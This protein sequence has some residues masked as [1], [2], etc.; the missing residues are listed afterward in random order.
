ML[1]SELE[2]FQDLFS[3]YPELLAFLHKDV[4]A[5]QDYHIDQMAPWMEALYQ[6]AEDAL[7]LALA[8]L[9]RNSLLLPLLENAVTDK[10]SIELER[11]CLCLL[12]LQAVEQK[13]YSFFSATPVLSGNPITQEQFEKLSQLLQSYF[14]GQTKKLL[15]L[16]L[17]LGD[18][19]KIRPLRTSLCKL[20]SIEEQ[21][22][23]QFI[24]ALFSKGYQQLGQIFPCLASLTEQEFEELRKI[25]TGF[26]YGHFVHTESTPREL[27]R[28]SRVL[29]ERGMD[30]LYKNILLQAF[31]VAGAAA[32]AQGKILLN[33]AIYATYF[34]DM[35][36][37]LLSLA[38]TSSQ[39]AYQAYLTKRL[40]I[41]E[42]FYSEPLTTLQQ[43]LGRLLCMFRIYDKNTATSF[44]QA[45]QNL[46]TD[47]EFVDSI[48]FLNE[49][50]SLP[51]Y[52]TPTYMPAFLNALK[53]QPRLLELAENS[54]ESMQQLVLRVGFGI[55]TDCLKAHQKLVIGNKLQ[56]INPLN[57]N[58][59]TGLVKSDFDAIIN[60][61]RTQDIAIG[62]ADGI[63]YPSTYL[64]MHKP[65]EVNK[66]VHNKAISTVHLTEFFNTDEQA[67]NNSSSD[68]Q[69]K[70]ELKNNT[71]LSC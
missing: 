28:L 9:P 13:N 40:K 22:P 62:K 15:R 20:F 53:D 65:Y 37:V 35:L 26:H 59:L 55:I 60:L 50:Q 71:S 18:F 63:I 1:N 43:L 31:D 41:C 3:S 2:Y 34:N 7:P 58:Q 27:E 10:R 57:F 39:E 64:T 11:T 69:S 45:L 4:D 56:S 61:Y 54:T 29:N 12:A 49:Y 19:G 52:S 17:L 42:Q 6:A 8:G 68:Q 67:K 48:N 44:E 38:N 66:Y 16:E 47:K 36:P 5:S 33:Q 25:N 24:A 23:D 51:E 30:Y 70:S 21:D 32:Q 46:F 14:P